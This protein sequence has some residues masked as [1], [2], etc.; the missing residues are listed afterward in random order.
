MWDGV[1]GLLGEFGV[2]CVPRTRA[3]KQR[4]VQYSPISFAHQPLQRVSKRIH[5]GHGGGDNMKICGKSDYYI[6]LLY[7]TIY[8]DYIILYAI[9]PYYNIFVCNI[10]TM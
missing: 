2:F 7:H 8:L 6:S 1:G 5:S 9:Y 10:D 4:Q 3:T